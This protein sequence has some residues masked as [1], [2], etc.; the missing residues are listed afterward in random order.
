M[1]V[2]MYLSV[3]MYVCIVC[4]YVCIHVMPVVRLP[5]KLTYC[6]FP[7][8]WVDPTHSGGA[9]NRKPGSYIYICNNVY[10]IRIG[11]DNPTRVSGRNVSCVSVSAVRVRESNYLMSSRT[12]SAT[13][14]A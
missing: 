11:Q 13:K 14:S 8:S 2:C 4:V 7:F 9:R 3:S 10:I 6:F 12:N 5:H 1:G